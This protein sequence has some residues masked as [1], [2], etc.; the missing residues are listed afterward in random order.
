MS[1]REWLRIA[2]ASSTERI[3]RMMVSSGEIVVTPSRKRESAR[4]S[5]YN[6]AFSGIVSRS[7]AR[8]FA[9]LSFR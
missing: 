9:P 8:F 5:Q 7:G 3:G 1:P 6:V 2:V 4:R